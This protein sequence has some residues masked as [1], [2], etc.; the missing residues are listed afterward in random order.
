M[1]VLVSQVTVIEA[2]TPV[3]NG[4]VQLGLPGFKT[5]TPHHKSKKKSRQNDSLSARLPDEH[6]YSEEGFDV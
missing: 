4:S 6:R 1:T 3:V 5:I 2:E